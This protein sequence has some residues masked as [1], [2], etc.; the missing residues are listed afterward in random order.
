MGKYIIYIY[1]FNF[2][3]VFV[4]EGVVVATG[5]IVVVKMLLLCY[6]AVEINC[7]FY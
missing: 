7:S 3:I 2:I 6:F 5:F 1:T 4:V